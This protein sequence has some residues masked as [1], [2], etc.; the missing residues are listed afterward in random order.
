MHEF[1]K[2]AQGTIEYL[3]VLAVIIV[4][5]LVVVGLVGSNT[6][7][8]NIS[9]TSGKIGNLTQGGISIADALVA[10]DGNGLISL[11]NNSGEMLTIT[12]I[13]VDG[14][15][16]NYNTQL[17][18]G[19]E[20]LF[21]LTALQNACSCAGNEGAKKTC[22]TIIYYT[23][24]SGLPT[25]I[26][27][28]INVDCVEQVTV[29]DSN[30]LIAPDNS[31]LRTKQWA[32]L[33]DW[34]EGADT[35][36]SISDELSIGVESTGVFQSIQA[37]NNVFQI[38]S[39]LSASDG[40][41]FLFSHNNGAGCG[42]GTA[43]SYW[44]SSD[45]V[46]FEKG[47]DFSNGGYTLQNLRS[48]AAIEFDG[49]Y[50]IGSGW[51]Q[52][53]PPFYSINKGTTWSPLAT[54]LP[55]GAVWL[56]HTFSYAIFNNKLYAG[57]GYG[58]NGGAVNEFATTQ[59]IVRD[60]PT[61]GVYSAVTKLVVADG[62]LYALYQG[63]PPGPGMPSAPAVTT[64]SDGVNWSSALSEL[65]YFTNM[66]EHD[67]KIRLSG[68]NSC[69]EPTGGSDY[70]IYEIQ[71]DGLLSVV[72]STGYLPITKPIT[73]HGVEYFTGL[74]RGESGEFLMKTTDGGE[75]I[76]LV[77]T[78]STGYDYVV[79]TSIRTH[80]DKIYFSPSIDTSQISNLVY[81]YADN[82]VYYSTARI[83]FNYN[84]GED[85]NWGIISW[86]AVTPSGTSISV[87]ARSAESE[88]GLADS[89]FF[90]IT[91]GVDQPSI[92]NN[93]WLQIRVVFSAD[94]NQLLSPTLSSLSVRYL[95]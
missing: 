15:D 43:A 63:V 74:I 6:T 1:E 86:E 81:S 72:N 56:M 23:T 12:R 47:G 55:E 33:S 64:T 57:T 22:N 40:N 82:N 61:N 67:G 84:A 27:F 20:I 41:L 92:Q 16:N 78:S 10:T 17:A 88:A 7:T 9:S 13:N 49:N 44:R 80:N 3:V 85:V 18:F 4:F 60:Q 32:S 90:E 46:T 28:S 70:N 65:K 89:T 91:N 51:C 95:E 39:F 24:Q 54:G 66:W 76:Q 93:V 62:N 50:F 83:D 94:S 75:T 45:G 8:Q 35:N 87:Q 53:K 21:S 29:I 59:W 5:S 37:I 79:P 58:T 36:I 26:S 34:G 19:S 25:K 71:E 42:G 30:K 38:N 52:A 77:D 14:A 48:D 31:V 73:Y 68:C 11:Q 69:T 2:Q